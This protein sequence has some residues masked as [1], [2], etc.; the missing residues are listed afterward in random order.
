MTWVTEA[1]QAGL[2]SGLSGSVSGAATGGSSGLLGRI[3]G[4]LNA[5]RQWKYQKKAMDL[6]QKYALEQMA[7][8]FEYGQK[9]WDYTFNKQNEYND[10]TAV[11]QR[12]RNAGA[13][14][15]AVLGQSG[16]SMGATL[17]GEMGSTGASGPSA[18]GAGSA[19]AFGPQY[20]MNAL[21]SAQLR[22]INAD[23]EHK[24]ADANYL[25]GETHT[26][27]YRKR[28]D[29]LD[30]K[31][32]D[33]SNKNA[34]EI[35]KINA[36]RAVIMDN[37]AQLSTIT[38]G[39]RLESV[40]ADLQILK[41]HADILRAQ[42]SALARQAEASYLAT[43]ATAFMYSESGK[44]EVTRRYLM[45]KQADLASH[46]ANL[47]EQQ[48][49][50]FKNQLDLDWNRE[51]EVPVFDKKGKV[52]ETHRMTLREMYAYMTTNEAS[53][54]SYMSLDAF[55]KMRSEKNKLGY[56][57]LLNLSALGFGA[58]GAALTKGRSLAGQPIGSET[59]TEYYGPDGD[60][61]GGS[62]RSDRKIYRQ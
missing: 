57:I 38:F 44:S 1:L 4:G 3:F 5:K 18:G 36:A 9:Q 58:A 40:M 62:R 10:P 41:D 15:A 17:G 12:F 27:D 8:Q 42:K 48:V 14:P 35:R 29:D 61:R 7:K 39:Y 23:T 53:A 24:Q 16:A 54:S 60:F 20:A 55:Y 51:F 59:T 43:L 11:F 32:G 30:L 37:D 52:T 26:V 33:L 21:S 28:R 22:N 31:A 2:S 25:R 50:D 47:T 45:S 19:S 49:I 46:Q 34:E 13:S 6:Q 56:G